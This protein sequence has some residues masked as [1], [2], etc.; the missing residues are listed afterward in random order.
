TQGVGQRFCLARKSA[1][2]ET[3]ATVAREK[4]SANGAKPRASAAFA[5]GG[6]K[7]LHDGSEDPDRPNNLWEP[8]PG[9]H[10]APGSFAQRASPF[11]LE[12]WLGM[13]RK[14]L[15]IAAGRIGGG[16]GGGALSQRP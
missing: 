11:S 2:I 12:L 7:R 4:V 14:W 6:H 9:D 3:G 16:G 15:A 5:G 1:A 13:H 8:V 10:G